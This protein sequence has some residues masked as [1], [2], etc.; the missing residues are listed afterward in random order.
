MHGDK[1]LKLEAVWTDDVSL[2]SQK[3]EC[4]IL[5]FF[6]KESGLQAYLERSNI[7]NSSKHMG[8]V[9][10]RPFNP[11]ARVDLGTLG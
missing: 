8:S 6:N 10:R 2:S 9:R 3:V 4:L 11:I 7:G 5:T 1:F